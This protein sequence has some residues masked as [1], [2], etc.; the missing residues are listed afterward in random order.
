MA[1]L[2]ADLNDTH[3]FND[4]WPPHARFHTAVLLFVS[5]GVSLIGLWLLWRPTAEFRSH[6]FL[7]MLI[8]M[9]SWGSFFP[10]LLI[11]GAAAEDVPGQLPRVAG[12]PLNLFVAAMFMLLSA[13]AW[14]LSVSSRRAPDSTRRLPL[15]ASAGSE[16]VA[17]RKV[18]R[19]RERR[20]VA[21]VVGPGVQAAVAIVYLARVGSGLRDAPDHGC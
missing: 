16:S 15:S 17:R 6:V 20:R 9:L 2:T 19:S 8:P 21:C 3:I 4:A 1:P 18:H 7:A 12:L 13:A 11:P 14:W 5:V 10:A